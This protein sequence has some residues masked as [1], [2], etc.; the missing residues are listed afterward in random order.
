MSRKRLNAL[1]IGAGNIGA[2]F[3]AP[4]SA[5]VL[6]HAHAY[7]NHSGFN[8][9]GFVDTNAAKRKKACALWGGTAYETMDEAFA[10]NKI[11]VASV[12][13]PDELHYPILMDLACRPVRAV[14]AEKPLAEKSAEA[15][16][17][18]RHYSRAHIS[19]C[20]NYTRRFVPEFYDIRRRI[21][22][23]SFGTYLTGTGYYGKG[24]LH[25]GSHMIDLIRFLI[26]NIGSFRVLGRATDFYPKDPSITAV[27]HLPGNGAFFMQA[28]DCKKFTVFE[29]DLLFSKERIR[30]LDSGFRIEEHKVGRDPVFK[31]YRKMVKVRDYTTSLSTALAL[32]A[33]GIY[34][35]VTKGVDLACSGLDGLAAVETCEGLARKA[36]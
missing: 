7:K 34:D 11:D 2:G 14:F 26:G 6:T 9:V 32:A 1:V 21:S 36:L 28:V 19:L 29:A 8:L 25:N 30:I 5:G 31:G 33:D 22:K 27:L 24:T 12:A 35:H 23:G 4:S 17:I 18:C 15:R 3:D 16:T 10:G 20:V 13:V